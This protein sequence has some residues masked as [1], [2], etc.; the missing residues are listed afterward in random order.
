MKQAAIRSLNIALPQVIQYGSKEVLT[1]M[2]KLPVAVPLHL[3]FTGFQGDGQ[4]D[5]VHHGGVEKA[6]CVYPIEHYGF[7][8]LEMDRKLG[9]AAFGENLTTEGLTE[10][11]VHIG[12][13]FLLG[14]AIVQISQPRQPCFKLSLRYDWSS[15]PLRVQETGY[16]GYYFRVL[17]EGTVALGDKFVLHQEHRLRISVSEANRLMHVDKHDRPGLLRLLAVEELS[18]SWQQRLY[19]R[20]EGGSEDDQARLKG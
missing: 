20:L 17:K 10:D 12:D 15:M 18:S 7:W 6:V 19:K 13:T 3:G 1:G 9:P 16:T 4:G 11:H 8:E 14:E 5:R 2:G